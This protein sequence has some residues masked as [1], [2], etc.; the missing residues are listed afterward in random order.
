MFS[1]LNV[2]KSKV[3]N[4]AIFQISLTIKVLQ[5]IFNS[6]LIFSIPILTATYTI[7]SY[8]KFQNDLFAEFMTNLVALAFALFFFSYF[9]NPNKL[10]KIKGEN[11]HLNIERSK[12]VI[13]KMKW[14]IIVENCEYMIACRPSLHERQLTLIFEKNDILLS[15]IRFGREKFVMSFHYDNAVL[16]QKQFLALKNLSN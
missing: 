5:F 4:K 13:K 16:F 11:L 8:S 2:E 7:Q 3:E 6:Y 10:I 14:E 9:K 15:S 1:N 12:E